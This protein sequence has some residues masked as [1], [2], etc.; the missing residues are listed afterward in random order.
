MQDRW[1]NVLY[2]HMNELSQ[3]ASSTQSDQ[4]QDKMFKNH[5]ILANNLYCAITSD[6]RLPQIIARETTFV[7]PTTV[8]TAC[9]PLHSIC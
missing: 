8:F 7:D 3:T 9:T 4:E 5:T 1:A 2:K 6:P